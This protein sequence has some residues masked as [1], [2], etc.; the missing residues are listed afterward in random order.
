M[1][2]IAKL[3]LVFTI[4][5]FSIQPTYAK[6]YG[7]KALSGFDTSNPSKTF[8]FE[9]L[10]EVN[11][12]GISFMANTVFKAKPYKIKDP[13]RLKRNAILVMKIVSYKYDNKTYPIK[14]LYV[15]YTTKFNT[16]ET[17]KN[18]ALSVGNCFVK[19]ISIGYKTVEGAVKNEE[20]NRFKSGA[21]AAYDATPVSL[22]EKGDA[23][24]IK[25]GN[26]MYL[27][28]KII[29]MTDISLSDRFIYSIEETEENE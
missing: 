24:V 5:F 20:G 23:I 18:V 6:I 10:E 25:E 9:T 21:M 19:G 1:K 2:N 13:Q 26:F 22:V 16:I 14:D 8:Y 11:V 17:T 4:L 29:D 7:V 28:F 3:L 12:D 27:K 15:K